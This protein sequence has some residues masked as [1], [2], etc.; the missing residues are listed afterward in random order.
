MS[1]QA[2]DLWA[3]L[4][5]DAKN[6]SEGMAKATATA[7]A[8]GKEME[9]SFGSRPQKALKDTEQEAA[10]VSW[11]MRGYIKDT[12]RV[13]TGI[14]ISQAFYQLIRTIREASRAVVDLA[15]DLEHAAISFKY[16]LGTE[17]AHMVPSLMKEIE[18]FAALTPYYM[19]ESVQAARRLLAAGYDLRHILPVM[20]LLTDAAAV[21]GANYEDLVDIFAKIRAQGRLTMREM[22]QFGRH[23][24]PAFDILAEQLGTTTAELSELGIT[25]IP[26]ETAINALLTGFQQRFG[27]AAEDVARSVKGLVNTIEDNIMFI[28]KDLFKPMFDNLAEKTLPRL[29][30]F[31]E[32]IRA[33]VS[34]I[35][36]AFLLEHFIPPELHHSV[37]AIVASLQ[38]M[39]VSLKYI[40]AAFWNAALV[41]AQFAITLLGPLLP[42]IAGIVRMLA[43]LIHVAFQS[44]K[45]MRILVGIIIG[46]AIAVPIATR[47]LWLVKAIGLLSIATYA[48]KAILYLRT[49]IIALVTVILKGGIPALLAFLAI[50][51]AVLTLSSQ[52]VRD[53][54]NNA[55]SAIAKLFDIDIS[56]VLQPIEPPDLPDLSGAIDPITEE[57]EDLA[58]TG[59]GKAVEDIADD[60]KDVKDKAKKA[61]EEFKKFLMPFDEVYTVAPPALDSLDDLKIPKL[62]DL[63]DLKD[64]L[65]GIGD[66]GA[67]SGIDIPFPDVP[68]IDYG[69]MFEGL[70]TGLGELA[71]VF[72]NFK[73]YFEGWRKWLL[74]ALLLLSPTVRRALRLLAG[75]LKLGLQWLL[76]TKL[77][78]WIVAGLKALW[79]KILGIG[80][81][82]WIVNLFRLIWGWIK[83]KITGLWASI[84]GLGWLKW[85]GNLF[86]LIGGWLKLKAGYVFGAGLWPAIKA[87]LIWLGKIIGVAVAAIGGW[88]VAALILALAALVAVFIKWGPEIKKWF[89]DKFGPAISK[90]WKWVGKQWQKVVEWIGPRVIDPLIKAW[91]GVKEWFDDKIGTPLAKAWEGV[92]EKWEAAVLWVDTKIIQPLVK[93]WK[94]LSDTLEAIFKTIADV[95][96][97]VWKDIKTIARGVWYYLSVYLPQRWSEIYEA[98]KTF[99][100]ENIGKGFQWLKDNVWDPLV[101]TW[102][103]VKNKVLEYWGNIKKAFID[104]WEKY[105][106][107]AFG[108]LKDNVWDPLVTTWENIK[109]SILGAWN[110]L[111]AKAREVWK[112]SIA[113]LFTW[114]KTNV[115]DPIVTTWETIK[116]RVTNVWNTLRTLASNVWRGIRDTIKGAINAIIGFINRL[117]SAWNRLRFS[118]PS[119]TMPEKLGGETI[120]GWSIGTHPIAHIPHLGTGGIV[121]RDTLA[122]IGERGQKEA[123]IPLNKRSLRPFAE[124]LGETLAPHLGAGAGAGA[125]AGLPIVYV[126]TLI[127]DKVGLREL[128]RRM[129]VVRLEEKGRGAG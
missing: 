62:K 54:V 72:E 127:A 4:S 63:K 42:A 39:W 25:S 38:H 129:R 14:L 3:Q 24:I 114:L 46:L 103:T 27:G 73:G 20:Q 8:A 15:M 120:G 118:M 26:V 71:D 116:T 12:A 109:E 119:I 65:S 99:W 93:S 40:A 49:A 35:G 123:V 21:S 81:I 41:A 36:P 60:L 86:R 11:V 77:G 84:I 23:G 32:T 55:I 76:G 122:R 79:A 106:G 78:K 124:A 110:A 56:G 121:T 97:P 53:F 58:D 66:L 64:A 70:E 51:V 44:S 16:L 125:G 92:L 75:W 107:P 52:A 61:K 126:H 96:G 98:F 47:V 6:F 43:Y 74:A 88:W 22:L 105:I 101:T 57:F 100:I 19:M 115:W 18:E 94:W 9:K 87:A 111:K 69:E 29:F 2:G 95:A 37:R 89:L 45:A 112:D 67:L 68:A 31:F 108:W 91:E 17:L 104:V 33:G 80:W 128:E 48:A 30:Q 117:I 13:I 59:A 83:L 10:K 82:A 50:V 90:A 5:L 28:A 7:K 1:V 34:K 113:P 102:E 85:I